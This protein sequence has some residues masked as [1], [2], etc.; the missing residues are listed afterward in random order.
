[1]EERTEIRGREEA[2]EELCG[3]IR[4]QTGRGAAARKP[5]GRSLEAGPCG[6]GPVSALPDLRASTLGD[7]CGLLGEG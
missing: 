3:R 5:R 7:Q 2:E 6:C 1:M 4:S